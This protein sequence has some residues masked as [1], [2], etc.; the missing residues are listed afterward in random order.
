MTAAPPSPSH[1]F[2][3][4]AETLEARPSGALWW[5]SRRWL[6]VADLHL[7]K[8]ERL[9][10]RGGPLLPPYETAET[11]RRLGDEIAALAPAA[12]ICLGDSFDDEAAGE[13]L[14]AEAAGRL[15]ALAAGRRWIWIAGNHDPGPLSLPGEH[16]G[17]L[18]EGVLTFRHEAAAE[19]PGLGR[20]E[21][22][23][24][25]HPKARLCA[26]GRVLSR[27]CFVVSR[28]GRVV[29]PAFGAYTGG[30]DARAAP[31]RRLAPE[32][33]A[34]LTGARVVAAPLSALSGRG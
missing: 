30:L 28:A 5:P 6:A 9:A 26:G 13:A 11:L 29:L 16:R 27:P 1:R 12:V 15:A 32:G 22:S 33:L 25:W 8:S 10:R 14:P 19:A 2:A 31:L 17:E 20:G 21:V 34:L 7:G 23:G 3:L 18:A 24:H 4:G